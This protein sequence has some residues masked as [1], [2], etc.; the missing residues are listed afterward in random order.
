MDSKGQK[1]PEKII[2][3]AELDQRAIRKWEEIQ[4]HV[5]NIKNRPAVVV[6]APIAPP[7]TPERLEKLSKEATAAFEGIIFYLVIPCV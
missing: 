4:Q 7:M 3:A 6:A 1:V 5:Q 2:S